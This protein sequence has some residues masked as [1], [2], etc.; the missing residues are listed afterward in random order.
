MGLSRVVLF[1]ETDN[2]RAQQVYESFGFRKSGKTTPPRRLGRR[3]GYG[4][5]RMDIP[6][7]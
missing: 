3:E 2:L 4:F 5:F 1:V 7:G 6:A